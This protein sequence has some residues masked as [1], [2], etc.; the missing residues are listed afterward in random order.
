MNNCVCGV[1]MALT[2]LVIFLM[3]TFSTLRKVIRIFICII[4]GTEMDN[5]LLFRDLKL[6]LHYG[7]ENVK[8]C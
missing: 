2:G 7:L 3:S 8:V 4:D 1:G 6:Y 5:Y